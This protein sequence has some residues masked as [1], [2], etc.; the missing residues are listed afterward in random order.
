MYITLFAN[1]PYTKEV[2]RIRH[3]PDD[4]LCEQEKAFRTK[5]S[6]ITKEHLEQLYNIPLAQDKIPTIGFV[7]SG[8]GFRSMLM[9]LGFLHGAQEIGVLHT[10]MYCAGLSG[11]TWAL[12]RWI[13][14]QKPLADF[15]TEITGRIDGGV[16]HIHDPYEIS[17]LFEILVTKIL[18]NQLIWT[19]DIYGAIIANTLLKKF[20]SKPMLAHFTDSHASINDALVPFPIYTAIESAHDPYEWV[21]FIPYEVGASFFCSATFQRGH[22]V[23]NLK[24]AFP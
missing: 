10:A 14:S 20:H 5:R 9:T 19:I 22:L 11:S 23:E 1:D 4:S 7:F 3:C 15:I 24:M 6:R 13:A 2:A 17:Q 16:D 8:G 21:E 12:A 18:C